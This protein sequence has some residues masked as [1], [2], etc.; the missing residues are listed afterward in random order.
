MWQIPIK[1]KNINVRKILF[2]LNLVDEI[3]KSCS[4]N[5]NIFITPDPSF[6][7][8][9]D[10]GTIHLDA[11]KTTKNGEIIA[12]NKPEAYGGI[13]WV[14]TWEMFKSIKKFSEHNFFLIRHKLRF[15]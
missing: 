8:F 9:S 10:E 2:Y 13:R 4:A 12:S 6:D 1:A 11:Y 3:E 15:Q 7:S 14:N 5:D